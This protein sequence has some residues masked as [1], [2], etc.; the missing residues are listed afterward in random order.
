M[1]NDDDERMKVTRRRKVSQEEGGGCER[2]RA[3]DEMEEKLWG[4]E[5]QEEQANHP[6]PQDTDEQ[7]EAKLRTKR[8]KPKRKNEEEQQK[9]RKEKQR[10]RKQVGDAQ[11]AKSARGTQG[12][13]SGMWQARWAEEETKDG[14]E[15]I[16]REEGQVQEAGQEWSIETDNGHE[17]DQ[18]VKPEKPEKPRRK[19]KE[20]EKMRKMKKEERENEVSLSNWMEEPEDGN[21]SRL[22]KISAFLLC[23]L[24]MHSRS[25]MSASST[26]REESIKDDEHEVSLPPSSFSFQ[27]NCAHSRSFVTG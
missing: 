3:E 23:F 5:E 27:I 9:E 17:H 12:K 14:E 24:M 11:K 22:P 20:E 21:Q 26:T 10:R 18:N 16:R 1:D 19:S 6:R 25:H 13:K 8:K 4:T 15:V 7:K 2:A